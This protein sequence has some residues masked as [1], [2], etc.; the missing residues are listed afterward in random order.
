MKKTKNIIT[1]AVAFILASFL[2]VAHAD[3]VSKGSVKSV[4]PDGTITISAGKNVGFE[5]GDVL[6]IQRNGQKIGLAHLAEVQAGYA[7]AQVISIEEG[8]EVSSGDTAAYELIS[9]SQS[10]DWLSTA[11]TKLPSSE[12]VPNILRQSQQPLYTG[13]AGGDATINNLLASL[14]K[15]PHN[16]MAMIKLADAYFSKNLYE[17]SINWNQK[18]IE[19]NPGAPDNDKLLYQV[20]R[21]YGFL[22]MKDKVD[23][24]TKFLNEKYPN[25]VF[26]NQE[27]RPRSRAAVSSAPS[28]PISITETGV[29]NRQLQ[30]SGMTGAYTNNVT[31]SNLL[32]D[33]RAP[34]RIGPSSLAG[35]S[36]GG[37]SQGGRIVPGSESSDYTAIDYSPTTSTSYDA[38]SV[39]DERFVE[40]EFTANDCGGNPYTDSEIEEKL[41]SMLEDGQCTQLAENE[42]PAAPGCFYKTY[43]ITCSEVK[44]PD[45]GEVV[46]PC[47]EEPDLRNRPMDSK[48]IAI[49]YPL[50]YPTAVVDKISDPKRTY[51]KPIRQLDGTLLVTDVYWKEIYYS[52]SGDFKQKKLYDKDNDGL[53]LY[54]DLGAACRFEA[55]LGYYTYFSEKK[56]EHDT[57]WRVD[58][59]AISIPGESEERW[60]QKE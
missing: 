52:E 59:R 53:W 20:I 31:A 38:C 48:A 17:Q 40:Y 43:G 18:A 37:A 5:E 41:R 42:K 19:E 4:S 51:V 36:I 30:K 22:N 39:P 16:R 46:V 1:T 13:A 23:L 55:R 58:T 7:T 47:T 60:K 28:R 27:L 11:A 34:Q 8:A 35:R 50:P 10:S 9:D 15:T 21:C 2:T 6:V 14:K 56:T 3:T 29:T 45:T 25:S 24:Y 44:N 54:G 12:P 32:A 57:K 49:S 33:E 26:A